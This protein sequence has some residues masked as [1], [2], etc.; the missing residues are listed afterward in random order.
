MQRFRDAAG[1]LD[2]HGRFRNAFLDR[3]VFD[4]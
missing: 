3:W 4:G 1:A 2:P